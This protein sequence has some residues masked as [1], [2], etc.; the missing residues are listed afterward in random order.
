VGGAM[1]AMVEILDCFALATIGRLVIGVGSGAGIVVCILIITESAPKEH[2]GYFGSLPNI[3]FGLG[4]VLSLLISLPSLMGTEQ[5]WPWAMAAGC[6]CA[7][8]CLIITLL[9]PDSPRYLYLNKNDPAAARRAILAYQGEEY[10]FE[11]E[12]DLQREQIASE[13]Q[14]ATLFG[15]LSRQPERRALFIC[16]V[17]ELGCQVSG[18][19]AIMAYS[20]TIFEQSGARRNA[21]TLGQC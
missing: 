1:N 14:K 3:F 8:L 21:A 4:D 15:L 2:R 11:T 20:T 19:A 12:M 5:L 17:L 18:I 13:E 10:L 9:Y 6:A 7:P 16:I